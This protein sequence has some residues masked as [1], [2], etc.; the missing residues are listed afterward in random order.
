MKPVYYLTDLK[1]S[2]NMQGIYFGAILLLLVSCNQQTQEK[3]IFGEKPF[4][5]EKYLVRYL[6]QEVKNTGCKAAID[7]TWTIIIQAANC[8]NCDIR[9]LRLIEKVLEINND[10]Y[11]VFTSKLSGAEKIDSTISHNCVYYDEGNYSKYGLFHKENYFFLMEDSTIKHW[12]YLTDENADSISAWLQAS[13][14][15]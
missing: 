11:V 12:A 8:G 4:D 5:K 13:N 2:N 15:R 14:Q 1:S 6:K 10:G 3:T 7:A 9:T